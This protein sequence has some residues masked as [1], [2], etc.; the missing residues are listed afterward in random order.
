M[1][2]RQNDGQTEMD[3]QTDKEKIPIRQPIYAGHTKMCGDDTEVHCL[4]DSQMCQCK[5]TFL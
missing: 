4:V 5:Q 3:K 1:I 2:N